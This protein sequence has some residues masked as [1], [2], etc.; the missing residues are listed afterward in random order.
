MEFRKYV[1]KS[2]HMA[3]KK[4]LL[5]LLLEEEGFNIRKTPVI[6]PRQSLAAPPLSFAQQRLWFLDQLEPGRPLYNIPVAYRLHGLLNV[7]A[8]E[9]SLNE[10]VRRHEVLRT[11][12]TTVDDQPVQVISAVASV[13]VRIVELEDSAG[14]DVDRELQ[15]LVSAEARRPFDLSTGLL[16]RATLFKL[17]EAEHVFLLTMHHIV[18]DGWS[19]DVFFGELSSLYE[20]LSLGKPAS[21]PRLPIQY[22]DFAV[23]QRQWLQGEVLEKQLGY[24]RQQ[25]ANAPPVLEL[26]TDHPRPQMQT[27]RGGKQ[28]LVI[29]ERLYEALKLL[30]NSEGVTLFMTLLAAFKLL[31]HR[32]TGQDDIVLGT[33]IAGRNRVEIEKLIGFFVNTLVLRT[34]V[35]GNPPFQR[36]LH[37][38]QKVTLGAY[39]NQDLPFEKLVEELQP[40]RDLLRNPLFQVFFNMV[41]VDTPGLELQGVQT[42]PVLIADPYLK[43][44]L[45]L[46]IKECNSDM[47]LQF[48]YNADLFGK[49]RI[50]EMLNQYRFLLSQ[51]VRHPEERIDF[52]S[53]ITPESEA[54]L[55]NLRTV[56]LEPRQEL[57]T[58]IITNRAESAPEKKALKQGERSLTYRELEGCAPLLAL[59]LTAKGAK[60]GDVVAIYGSRSFGLIA[61]MLGVLQCGGVMLPLDSGLPDQRKQQMLREASAKY[62]VYVGERRKEDSWLDRI[63]GIDILGIDAETAR[64]TDAGQ[65]AD[66]ATI[67][68]PTVSPDDPA[69]IFFTSGTTGVPKGILGC[70]KGLSHFLNWQGESFGVGPQDRVA[71]L[72]NL[73]FDVVLRDIFL[74]LTHGGTLC[75]PEAKDMEAARA[76]LNWFIMPICLVRIK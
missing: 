68:L 48:V 36:L 29:S 74:P 52:F 26:P 35:S 20:A 41:N 11:S 51:V 57:V 71:Q 2:E 72:T 44:D 49:G 43:F 30:S 17:T 32:Y 31:L 65:R 53:L 8:L 42:E 21:L 5:A 25:L 64:V 76:L 15:R 63:A 18:S 60:K 28:S 16:I 62:L 27:Y 37:R 55:P 7:K 14:P 73:S 75:L 13:T 24:W 22:A 46:Y 38:I 10:I 54:L 4:Q 59:A 3:A 67:R 47:E 40:E 70:H 45:T 34:D 23:W 66:P 39:S 6:E 1:N 50:H 56:L 19:L 58:H 69:Y 12:F 9:Q 61:G 33:P